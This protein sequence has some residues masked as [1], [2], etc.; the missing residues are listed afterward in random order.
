MGNSSKLRDQLAKMVGL[1][2]AALDTALDSLVHD[3][4]S[5]EAARINNGGTLE[6]LQYLQLLPDVADDPERLEGLA[7]LLRRTL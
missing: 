1:S 6:Q 2:P 7:A 5:Q 3:K 4:K